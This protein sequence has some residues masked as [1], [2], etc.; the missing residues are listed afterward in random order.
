M[1]EE[2]VA[3]NGMLFLDSSVVKREIKREDLKVFKIP[4]SDIAVDLGSNQVSNLILLGAV[5]KAT[6]ILPLE[7]IET[8]LERKL[9][10]E[11]KESL[12]PVNKQA[13]ERGAGLA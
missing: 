10:E 4:A 5:A 12:I 11:G 1:F 9:R 7:E 2:K 6:D 13:L 3:P 8:E